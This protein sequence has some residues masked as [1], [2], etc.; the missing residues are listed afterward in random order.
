[1]GAD[2]AEVIE[3]ARSVGKT[4][5]SLSAYS[6]G[7]RAKLRSTIEWGE[8]EDTLFHFDGFR[9]SSRSIG[10]WI[11]LAPDLKC[12]GRDGQEQRRSHN[13]EPQRETH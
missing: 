5:G 1:M 12:E 6:G 11:G 9:R 2:H 7:P 3:T 4:I 13:H 8:T 10:A